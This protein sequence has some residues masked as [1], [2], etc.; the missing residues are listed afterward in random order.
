MINPVFLHVSGAY[1]GQYSVAVHSSLFI[2]S[3]YPVYAVLIAWNRIHWLVLHRPSAWRT[4][5]RARCLRA[6]ATSTVTNSQRSG[7]QS[8]GLSLVVYRST[9]SYSSLCRRMRA[10][11]KSGCMPG[12]LAYLNGTLFMKPSS[13]PISHHQ[14]TSACVSSPT[15]FVVS[16]ILQG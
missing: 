12:Q 13:P 7:G 11:A 9:S 4:A 5:L 16:P 3:E 1:C 10:L 2:G 8:G 15:T 14:T 6:W